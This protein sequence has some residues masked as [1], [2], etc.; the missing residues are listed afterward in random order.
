MEL[1]GTLVACSAPS[2]K[3]KT[4][5]HLFFRAHDPVS[6]DNPQSF[7]ITAHKVQASTHGREVN[8]SAKP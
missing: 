5:Q 6:Q 2:G 4:E 7:P 3:D 1:A 8:A